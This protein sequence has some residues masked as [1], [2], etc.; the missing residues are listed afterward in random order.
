M[1]DLRARWIAPAA[2]AV[3]LASAGL[4]L[5]LL[6]RLREP[7]RVAGPA[8]SRVLDR[9]AQADVRLKYQ[10]RI[11][12][13]TPVHFDIPIDEQYRV[14]INTRL[15]IDTKVRLPIRSPL[16]NYTVNVP[17]KADVPI[18]T[19]IPLQL[20]DTFRLRT[21][22]Q[23]ELVVPLEVRIRDLPLDALRKSFEP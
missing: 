13:G 4:N 12:A 19:E 2:L 6:G 14:K 18:R 20:R 10:I 5:V 7:E 23:A 11:A 21:A 15:P 17:V 22:T 1:F 3:A 16:G 8:L 9:L